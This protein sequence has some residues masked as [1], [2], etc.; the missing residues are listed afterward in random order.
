MMTR[1]GTLAA[2]HRDLRP[3]RVA[4][5]GD[6]NAVHVGRRTGEDEALRLAGRVEGIDVLGPETELDGSGR[7]F[8]R[9]G[10]KRQ[11]GFPGVE[12][13]PERRLEPGFQSQRV[14]IE[15]HRGVH[16]ADELDRM[17]EAHHVLPLS[18]MAPHPTDARPKRLALQRLGNVNIL[19]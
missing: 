3:L 5:T 8:G 4:K 17:Y 10:V 15:R 1:R 9:S 6:A 11:P 19:T 14:A 2:A 13:A 18:L 12:L 16:V 7:V